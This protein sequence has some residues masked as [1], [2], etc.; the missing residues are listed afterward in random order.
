MG[1]RFELPP[2]WNIYS[3]MESRDALLAWVTESTAKGGSDLLEVSA[4]Q[5]AEVDGAGLQLLAALGHQDTA[6]KLVDASDAF[7]AA[8]HTLGFSRWVQGL[9]NGQKEA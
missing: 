5:V 6:W 7:V 3:V 2:E 8:C 9:P 4:S 1:K